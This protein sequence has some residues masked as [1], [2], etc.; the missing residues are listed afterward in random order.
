MEEIDPLS[1]VFFPEDSLPPLKRILSHYTSENNE[2]R[3]VQGQRGVEGGGGDIRVKG[4]FE[5]S[6]FI[7]LMS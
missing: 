4:G 3:Y 1:D 6:H 2:D 5:R 7:N